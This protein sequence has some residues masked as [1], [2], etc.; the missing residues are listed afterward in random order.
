MSRKVGKLPDSLIY[1]TISIYLVWPC[2]HDTFDG[3]GISGGTCRCCDTK[4]ILVDGFWLAPCDQ[5]ASRTL[6]GKIL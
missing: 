4:I 2:D 3:F 6:D 1:C 5:K